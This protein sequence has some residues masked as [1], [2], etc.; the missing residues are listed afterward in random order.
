MKYEIRQIDAWNCGDGWSYN[1]TWHIGQYETNASDEKKAFLRQ[2]HKH[3]IVC[4]R[5]K[6]VVEFDG[7]CYELQDRKT[8]EP[9]FVAIP[10]EG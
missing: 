10:M 3:G 9:L 6:C 1:E 7:D 4:N 8:R 5:G 2:L